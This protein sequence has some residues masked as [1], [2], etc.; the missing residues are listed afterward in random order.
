MRTK[1]VLVTAVLLAAAGGVRA[2]DPPAVYK[3]GEGVTAPI[4]VR[5]VKPHYTA[6]AMKER[7]EGVVVLSA[8]VLEDGTV[9]DVQV[10]RS[11]DDKYGLDEEAVNALKQWTFRPGTKDGKPVRVQV[12]V[13]MA[14]TLKK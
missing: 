9:G 13:E 3:T 8:V 11:L 7:I 12:T 14:F 10:T 2:Q 6:Q 1:F 4:V 5:D